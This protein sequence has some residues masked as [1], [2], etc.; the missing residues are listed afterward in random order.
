MLVIK[1]YF[2]KFSFCVLWKK[3]CNFHV[4]IELVW[5]VLSKTWIF[6]IFHLKRNTNNSLPSVSQNSFSAW[7]DLMARVFFY[8]YSQNWIPGEKRKLEN[9]S[10]K[11]NFKKGIVETNRNS[12]ITFLS[13]TNSIESQSLTTDK[14]AKGIPNEFQ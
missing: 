6:T 7:G 13:L 12:R 1:N 11:E 4:I 10:W 5:L 9:L 3:K 8:L 14:I 2:F